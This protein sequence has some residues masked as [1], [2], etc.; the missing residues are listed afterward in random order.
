MSK[1][2]NESILKGA[3]EALEYAKN[4]KGY[5]LVCDKELKNCMG[6]EFFYPVG[7]IIIQA[8]GNY[9]SAVFDPIGEGYPYL[10]MYV[11]DPCLK[12]KVSSGRIFS[13]RKEH[14]TNEIRKVCTE[15]DI[16][17]D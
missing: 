3:R 7:G 17:L 15:E 2:V 1:K 13:V 4:D 12:Q 8:G 14:I 5:C 10:E 6:P 11:C 16:R 9:G